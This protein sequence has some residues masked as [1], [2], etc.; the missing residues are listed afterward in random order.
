MMNPFSESIALETSCTGLSGRTGNGPQCLLRL[1]RL[2][3]VTAIVTCVLLGFGPGGDRAKGDL[4]SVGSP[5]AAGNNTFTF[6][7][8][9][10][11]PVVTPVTK[12][13]TIEDKVTDIVNNLTAAGITASAGAIAGTI[14]VVVPAGK[15]LSVTGPAGDPAY[16][17]VGT[18][19]AGS[20]IMGGF[21]GVLTG[22]D[23]S[24]AVATYS[25]A[26][27]APGF[28]VSTTLSYNDLATKTI[29]GL[30]TQVFNN[31][32][33]QLPTPDKSNLSLDLADGTLNYTF[34][35]APTTNP[36]VS[37]DTTD[38]GITCL[39]CGPQAVPEP[40]MIVLFLAGG[41]MLVGRATRTW[42]AKPASP[43]TNRV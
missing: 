24:G 1:A 14:N 41:V 2:G 21:S 27:S 8:A 40:S 42:R 38:T 19:P 5:T 29:N 34:A 35:G 9:P 31:L 23:A 30:L 28:N 6:K 12:G 16:Q 37:T 39:V 7:P 3:R 11:A 13:E 26:F 36:F 10:P 25:M 22:K 18:F 43:L 32:D 15:T 20:M 4:I 33:A 17:A